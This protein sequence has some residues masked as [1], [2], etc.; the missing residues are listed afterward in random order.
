MTR[1]EESHKAR[2]REFRRIAFAILIVGG[3][4]SAVVIYVVAHFLAKVW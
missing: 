3:S 1:M 2:Q 4:L